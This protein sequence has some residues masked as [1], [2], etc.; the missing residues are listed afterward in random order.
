MMWFI[1]ILLILLCFAAGFVIGFAVGKDL[2]EE[3]DWMDDDED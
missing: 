2:D 1:T 3:Q